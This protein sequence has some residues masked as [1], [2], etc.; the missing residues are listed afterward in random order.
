MSVKHP[1]VLFGLVSGLAAAADLRLVDAV[2]NQD[3]DAVRELLQKH[4]DV[5]ASQGDGATA[6][7]WAAHWDDLAL[8]DM[9]IR[10]HANVDAANDLGVTPL[11]LASSTAMVEKLL[12]AGAN[13]NVVMATGESPLM[14]AARTGSA[15][16]VKALLKHGAGVNEK[17]KVRGQTALMWAVSQKHPEIVRVLIEHGADVH[18]RTL[19]SPQLFYTGEP[20]GA[21]R[22]RTDW[23]MRTIETGGSNAPM[24][25]ARQGG[26]GSAEQLLGA[27]AH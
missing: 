23:V 11:T 22:S 6:L 20:A 10:A 2:K 3:R 4:A 17:E 19:S 12:A 25:A 15:E 21:G 5:N 9:L 14:A 8:A 27:G 18:A 13:P 26:L 1:L 7:H 24:V 16:M